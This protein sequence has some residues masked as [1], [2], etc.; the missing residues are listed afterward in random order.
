MKVNQEKQ[1]GSTEVIKSYLNFFKTNAYF[2]NK[3]PLPS[4][5][6]CSNESNAVQNIKVTMTV[7]VFKKNTFPFSIYSSIYCSRF[8]SDVL[9]IPFDASLQRSNLA[10]VVYNNL[11]IFRFFDNK[12][13]RCTRLSST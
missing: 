7:I 9:K 13:K 3:S 11:N 6:L 8:T 5:N 2:S 4:Y 1:F 10:V 12:D